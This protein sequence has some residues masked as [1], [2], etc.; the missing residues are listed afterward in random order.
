[1]RNPIKRWKLSPMDLESRKHWV[2]YSRAKD[3]MLQHTD[4]KRTPWFI[5]DADNK[6]RARLNCIAH[7]LTRSPTRTCSRSRS[8]CRRASR[9][10]AK[11]PEEV[12]PA[13]DSRTL[14]G[15]RPRS[16]RVFAPALVA[17]AGGWRRGFFPRLYV[18]SHRG[19]D[20]SS[21]AKSL[22]SGSARRM[23]S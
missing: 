7:L 16:G 6:K 13:L 20:K 5:V 9:I 3:I 11:A 22:W 4:R 15:F 12:E 18:S 14:L 1:M 21:G 17:T 10:P 2:E 19:M 8:I 23:S